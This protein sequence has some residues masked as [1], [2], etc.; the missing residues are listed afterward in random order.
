MR[1][2]L[3]LIGLLVVLALVA[4]MTRKSLDTTRAAI[5]TLHVGPAASGASAPA[6]VRE[7]SQQIQQQ[8]QKALDSA[9]NQPRAEPAE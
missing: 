6:T 9:L 5:P 7:Q 1:A 2:G 3:G 4:L 8:Y